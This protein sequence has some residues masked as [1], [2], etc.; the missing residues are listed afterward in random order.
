MS[1]ISTLTVGGTQYDI[2]AALNKVTAKNTENDCLPTGADEIQWFRT[3]TSATGADGYVLGIN[4]SQTGKWATQLYMDVDPTYC[5]SI[6]HR[7]SNGTWKDWKKILTE[8]NY[9]DFTVTKTG[10]GA[11]GTWGINVS[12]TAGGV[13]WG[14][15]TGKPSSFT[16]SS[17]THDTVSNVKFYEG[18]FNAGKGYINWIKIASINTGTNNYLSQGCYDFEITRSYNSPAPESYSIRVNTGWNN[19]SITQING[20]ASSRIIEKFRIVKDDTNHLAYFE[21]YV[22]PSY[23]TYEN[24]GNIK[25]VRYYGQD[26]T[27]LNTKQ[28]EAD[29]AFS[30]VATLNLSNGISSTNNVQAASFNGYTIAKSVPSNADFTNTWRG[31]QDNLTS[32]TNTTESLS[33]KQGYLLANGSARD[34]TKIPLDGSNTATRLRVVNDNSDTADDAMIYLQNKSNKDWATKIELGEYSYGLK[35]GGTGTQLLSVGNSPALLVQ[36]NATAGNGSVAIKGLLTVTKN[37]N[38]VT[39]GS[40][41]SGWC[42]FENS[43]NISFHFNRNVYVQGDIYKY[44]SPNVKVSYE[45]HSHAWSEITDKPSSFTPASHTHYSLATIGD[46]RSTATTP[47]TYAN[48]LQF[49]GLKN[50]STIGSPSTDTYSYLVGLRGWSDS[51][52]G[53][54]HELAFNNTGIYWRNGATTSWGNWARIYT[55]ANKPSWDD[56]QSKPSSFT[57]ASHTHASNALTDIALTW[58]SSVSTTD[59]F[60]AHDTSV[61][62]KVLFRAISPANVRTTIGAAASSHGHGVNTTSVN[63]TS[64]SV[65]SGTTK[66]VITTTAVTV[67]TSVKNS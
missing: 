36:D 23:T 9:T 6:R 46:Q 35:I 47:N 17:H 34:S 38:T 55:T 24:S 59:W 25:I 51:S 48:T 27:L 22:N 45:G 31:I 37:G 2:K 53:N 33:A 16:P 30:I 11:S 62:D 12:G 39:I 26:I 43:A 60:L 8:N 44:G 21:I 13:A 19:A 14:N 28:T 56:I 54:S 65:P 61:T 66:L 52:G 64:A 18:D 49:L 67:A 42:H 3:S 20:V 50:N 15:V 63:S 29:S 1:N 4:W 40:Q 10:S 57:P 41:N 5:M 7:D 32:S 58:T